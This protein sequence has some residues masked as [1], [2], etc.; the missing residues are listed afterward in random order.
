MKILSVTCLF[1]A[2]AVGAAFAD[3]LTRTVQ[4]KLKDGGFYY[5]EVNGQGGAE[6]SAALRRYQIRY[7]LRVTGEL[8]DET[9][10]A[11]QVNRGRTNPTPAPPPPLAAPSPAQPPTRDPYPEDRGRPL[12]D[13][14]RE[15][16][17][18]TS[19]PYADPGDRPYARPTLGDPF[20]GTVYER[21]PVALQENILFAAQGQLARR[22]FY[23]GDLD[24]RLGPA[25]TDALVRFQRDRDLPVSGRLDEET[26]DGLELLPGQRHGPPERLGRFDEAP[27]SRRV[28]RGL[29]INP[30]R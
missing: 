22:G 10:R 18:W 17:P 23:R 5:G 6:T 21:A 12:D 16:A 4:Q 13:S 2:V 25:T 8:N 1:L 27:P 9:L 15:P 26:L 20:A 7:G 24:G 14:R 29:W 30:E 3:D 11:L 19:D 28:Y